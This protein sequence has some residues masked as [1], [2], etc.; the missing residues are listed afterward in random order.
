MRIEDISKGYDFARRGLGME[1]KHVYVGV[2]DPKSFKCDAWETTYFEPEEIDLKTMLK[3]AFHEAGK[4]SVIYL[5]F[6]GLSYQI[7]DLEG[8]EIG[9]LDEGILSSDMK[10]IKDDFLHSLINEETK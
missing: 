5:Y 10:L 4:E 8:D 1:F 6:S 9:G 3:I 2:E 7:K